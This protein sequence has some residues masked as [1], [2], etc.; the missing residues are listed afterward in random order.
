[1]LPEGLRYYLP[2]VLDYLKSDESRQDWHMSEGLLG[3]LSFQVR[4]T[5][6]PDDVLRLIGSIADY[7][8]QNRTKFLFEWVSPE[9]ERSVRDIREALRGG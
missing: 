5:K 9:F 2:A 1:M 7:V 8:D 6:L 4:H 3:S